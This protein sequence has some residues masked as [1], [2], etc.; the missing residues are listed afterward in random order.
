MDL[1]AHWRESFGGDP[2]PLQEVA[3]GTDT[4]DTRARFSAQV[5]RLRFGAC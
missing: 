2:P 4:D 1:A 3:I 5:E